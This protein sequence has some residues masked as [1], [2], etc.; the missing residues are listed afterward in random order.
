MS[1]EQQSDVYAYNQ[2]EERQLLAYLESVDNNTQ[3]QQAQGGY[4]GASAG[5]GQ[6]AADMEAELAAKMAIGTYE[7]MVKA[8]IHKDFKLPPELKEE[9]VT[10]YKPVINKYAP[11]V[12]MVL[13]KWGDELAATWIT[14]VII[15]QSFDGLKELKQAE[16][17]AKQAANDGGESASKPS[18][19]ATQAER[20]KPKKVGWF[21]GKAA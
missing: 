16:H 1:E 14:C 21:G 18:N 4:G 17:D 13:A 12:M 3:Q 7:T 6:S 19:D 10:K 2:D 5:G 15:K 20:K 8:L 9:A 11:S